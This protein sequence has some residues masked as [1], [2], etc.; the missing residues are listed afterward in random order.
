MG[1]TN[2]QALKKLFFHYPFFFLYSFLTHYT[3]LTFPHCHFCLLSQTGFW[4]PSQSRQ[5][6]VK[7][8]L[9][10]QGS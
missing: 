7:F 5:W 6:N 4:L 8:P 1:T 9:K 3:M 10:L 2:N